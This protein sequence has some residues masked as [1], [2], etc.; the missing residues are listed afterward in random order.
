[1]TLDEPL[2]HDHLVQPFLEQADVDSADPPFVGGATPWWGDGGTINAEV[3]LLS[4]NII[5]QGA[6]KYVELK[7][8]MIHK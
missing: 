3:G 2:D 4:H 7:F 1:M 6:Y 5:I 8:T